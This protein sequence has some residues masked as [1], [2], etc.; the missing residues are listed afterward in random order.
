MIKIGLF[1]YGVVAQGFYQL[2]S[3]NPQ[4][5]CSIKTICVQDSKKTRNLDNRLFTT[6]AKKI[7]D[8]PEIE[9]IVEL[10]DD[11]EAAYV[12]VKEALTK[13]R[14]VISANK[15]MIAE[16]IDEVARWHIE[17]TG[18]LL[19]EAAV[20]GSI[21][22]IHNIE[23]FFAQQKIGPLRA[24]LNGSCNY[25]LSKMREENIDFETGVKLAQENGFAESDPTLDISGKDT[26]YKLIILAYHAY[27]E[28]V[29]E[30][31][32]RL[33]GLDNLESWFFDAAKANGQKIKLIATAEYKGDRYRYKVQPELIDPEDLLFGVEFETNAVLIKG[34]FSGPQLY[35][36]KGA[37]G[38]PT[39]SAV[40]NDLALL[41]KGF[42]YSQKRSSILVDTQ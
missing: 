13:G 41:L 12:I 7:L 32:I 35:A 36:G 29:G 21:P 14:S 34:S 33:E 39:G 5:N 3:Q 24:I 17:M 1:G 6:D 4:L 23:Q 9:V 10:I 19:Y 26:L 27:G 37:G 15:K 30:D 18:T 11:A 42:R 2:L 40:I 28:I 16:N 20:A 22:I 8:D 25:I 38:E 31:K